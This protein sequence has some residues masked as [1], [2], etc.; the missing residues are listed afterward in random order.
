MATG[1]SGRKSAAESA[2]LVGLQ[3]GF[4]SD[5]TGVVFFGVDKGFL[6][7]GWLGRVQL[8]LPTCGGAIFR[9]DRD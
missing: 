5:A 4:L 7:V 2:E 3:R 6:P 8:D 1:V 9:S